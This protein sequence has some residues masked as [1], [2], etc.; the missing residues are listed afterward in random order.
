MAKPRKKRGKRERKNIETGIAFI[1]STFNNTIVT[2]TDPRGN[3]V[4]YS[5]DPLNRPA[6]ITQPDG[7]TIHYDYDGHGNP[8]SIID[9]EGQS[10]DYEYDDMGR[11]TA[12]SSP[13]TGSNSRVASKL[14]GLSAG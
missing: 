3:T 12:V 5:Y 11:I 9:S 8:A 7:P 13:D 1:Q 10:T 14:P 4:S 2:I 6:S